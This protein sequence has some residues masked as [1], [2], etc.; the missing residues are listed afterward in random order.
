MKKTIDDMNFHQIK[1]KIDDRKYAV[2]ALTNFE[3]VQSAVAG[4]EVRT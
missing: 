3:F 2:A 1:F 4:G